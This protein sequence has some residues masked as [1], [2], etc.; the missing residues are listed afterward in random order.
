ME[1][2]RQPAAARLRIYTGKG[3]GL[4]WG[5]VRP[6]LKDGIFAGCGSGK[7]R[8]GL[9][10][11]GGG[12]RG[13]EVAAFGI[14]LLEQGLDPSLCATSVVV[15]LFGFAVFVDGALALT[16]QIENFAQINVAP[17]FGP[18][19]RRLGHVLQDFAER[20]GGSLIVLLVEE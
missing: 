12:R 7:R 14:G 17:D 6:L 2:Q 4:L 15:G 18:L 16:Q 13:N 19:L 11:L 1:R 5:G 3:E 8:S 20:V 9:C 10:G